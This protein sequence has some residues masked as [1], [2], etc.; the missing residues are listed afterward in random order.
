M[1]YPTRNAQSRRPSL[2]KMSMTEKTDYVAVL[3]IYVFLCQKYNYIFKIT[4][5]NQFFFQN[6]ILQIHLLNCH[7]LF[8]SLLSIN[9][10]SLT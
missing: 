10:H 3:L 6:N 4:C 1:R 5:M 7:Y 2:L 8:F 9:G